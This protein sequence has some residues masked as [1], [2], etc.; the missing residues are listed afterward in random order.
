MKTHPI[1]M[2][3]CLKM[4]FTAIFTAQ[5]HLDDDQP[6]GKPVTGHP[7]LGF[8]EKYP[9][10]RCCIAD[11]RHAYLQ[12]KMLGRS[13]PC[14]KLYFVNPYYLTIG[15]RIQTY[16]T[17]IMTIESGCWCRPINMGH[18]NLGVEIFCHKTGLYNVCFRLHGFKWFLFSRP[19][20]CCH[21]QSPMSSPS[22]PLFG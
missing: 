13:Q 21:P 12:T 10:F 20:N 9:T 14:A 8:A 5:F 19:T 15:I 11:F 22:N 3:M 6:I 17:G 2:W 18:F 4:G 16:K 1:F 7:L